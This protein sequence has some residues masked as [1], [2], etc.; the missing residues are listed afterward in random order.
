MT[1]RRCTRST[2]T[3]WFVL[4]LWG[5]RSTSIEV[6]GDPAPPPPEGFSVERFEAVEADGLLAFEI[7]PGTTGIQVFARLREPTRGSTLGATIVEGPPGTRDSQIRVRGRTSGVQGQ[8]RLVQV[9]RHL[10]SVSLRPRNLGL[11]EGQSGPVVGIDPLDHASSLL[12]RGLRAHEVV[13][14][15]QDVDEVSQRDALGP[16]VAQLLAERDRSAQIGDALGSF[17]ARLAFVDL[18]WSAFTKKTHGSVAPDFHR[19]TLA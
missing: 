2:V 18:S 9:A 10:F 3:P 5:C 12:Q 1:D 14:V 7:E 13:E 4:A 19:L 6:D 16:G 17:L 15:E 11:S 8:L